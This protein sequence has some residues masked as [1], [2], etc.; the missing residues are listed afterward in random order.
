MNELLFLRDSV[1]IKM[2]YQPPFPVT[3]GKPD[4]IKD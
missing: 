2:N 3:I 4:P 1:H